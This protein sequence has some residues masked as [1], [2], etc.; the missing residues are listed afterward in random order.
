MVRGSGAGR[1]A[2]VMRRYG[3]RYLRTRPSPIRRYGNQSVRSQS[4]GCLTK[5]QVNVASALRS[6]ALVRPGRH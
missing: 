3:M 2:A 5:R 1:Q 4:V 6:I